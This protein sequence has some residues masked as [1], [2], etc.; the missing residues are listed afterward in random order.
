MNLTRK[1][2]I[3]IIFSFIYLSICYSQDRKRTRREIYEK[4][5]KKRNHFYSADIVKIDID[6]EVVGPFCKSLIEIDFQNNRVDADTCEGRIHFKINKNSFIKKVELLTDNCWIPDATVL[7]E[8]GQQSYNIFSNQRTNNPVH[9]RASL[10][11]P[12]EILKR[13]DDNEFYLSVFP[14]KQGQFEKIRLE[15]YSLLESNES[16]DFVWLFDILEKEDWMP[17]VDSDNIY[18]VNIRIQ[19]TKLFNYSINNENIFK[20][21]NKEYLYAGTFRDNIEIVYQYKNDIQ[22]YQIN[23]FNFSR[24]IDRYQRKEICI[25][26][27]ELLNTL[28]KNVFSE[29]DKYI[30]IDYPELQNNTFLRKFVDYLRK[31]RGYDIC[32]GKNWFDHSMNDILLDENYI[33]SYNKNINSNEMEVL[34]CDFVNEFVHYFQNYHQ[35]IKTKT[36][37]GILSSTTIKRISIK[38]TKNEQVLLKKLNIEYNVLAAGGGHPFYNS[39]PKPI[40]GYESIQSRAVYPNEAIEKKIEGKVGVIMWINE[41]GEI[42]HADIMHSTNDIFNESALR[43]VKMTEFKPATLGKYNKPAGCKIS[44]FVDFKLD[45][46]K[47]EQVNLLEKNFLKLQKDVYMVIDE[48]ITQVFDLEFDSENNTEYFYDSIELYDLMYSKPKLIKYID[49]ISKHDIEYAGICIDG[50]SYLIRFPIK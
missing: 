40:G 31:H 47:T 7:F 15:V 8:N 48:N 3:V 41:Y 1:L 29:F 20:I 44:I 50:E 32:F 42:T 26:K 13:F 27:D 5:D 35:P 43:A 36:K 16:G 19:N 4:M 30:I 18:F 37:E 33:L 17:Y 28:I 23:D 22:N 14:V 45:S 24:E 12:N 25:L 6:H 2:L 49:K 39:S 46:I 11:N 21:F 9:H 38:D 34:H 10:Y